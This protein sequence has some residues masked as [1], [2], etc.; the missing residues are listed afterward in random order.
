MVHRYV[1]P[2]VRI[3]PATAQLVKSEPEFT[4][5]VPLGLV[6]DLLVKEAVVARTKK[7]NRNK[8]K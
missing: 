1:M 8:T 3:K 7:R 4:P 6:V 5:L 2:Q